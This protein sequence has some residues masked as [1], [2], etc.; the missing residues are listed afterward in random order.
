MWIGPLSL[1]IFDMVTWIVGFGPVTGVDWFDQDRRGAMFFW[2]LLGW[3]P[4]L[5]V[6]A[7]GAQIGDLG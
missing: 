7:L 4:M 3:V 6:A 2:T 1:A 5:P